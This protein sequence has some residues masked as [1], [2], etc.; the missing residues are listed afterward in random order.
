MYR[1]QIAR[2]ALDSS[3]LCCLTQ[4]CPIVAPTYPLPIPLRAM[5]ASYRH[6]RPKVAPPDSPS[7]KTQNFSPVRRLAYSALIWA[8]RITLAQVSISTLMRVANS[9]GVLATGS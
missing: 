3:R 2:D 6:V 1:R 5:A 4:N 8:A 9:S 7:G